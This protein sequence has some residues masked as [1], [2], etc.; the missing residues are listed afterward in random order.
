[1]FDG[2]DEGH[3]LYEF[4]QSDEHMWFY[5]D[6]QGCTQGTFSDAQ[7]HEWFLTGIYFTPQLHIR[8][9]CDDTFS[10][11]GKLFYLF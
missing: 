1:M 11:L 10:P 5:E 6:P 4:N 8:R 7:M 3:G 9:K 2:L